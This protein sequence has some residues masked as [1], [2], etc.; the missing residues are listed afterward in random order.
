MIVNLRRQSA[1]L[2]WMAELAVKRRALGRSWLVASIV[3]VKAALTLA[4]DNRYGFHRDE[5]YY[6]VSGRRLD[7]GYV[8]FP[9]LTPVLARVADTLFGGSLLGLRSLALGAGVATLLLTVAMTRHLG[10]HARAQWL[11]ALSVATCGFYL[12]ANG[13]FQTVSFDILAWAVGLYMF[14]RL[15][16]SGN[17]RWWLGVG[18]AVGVGMETKYT[19]PAFVAGLAVATAFT[20]LRRDLRTP[21]PWLGAVI[22]LVIAAPNLA[23]QATQGW[24]SIEFLRGQNARVRGQNPIPKYLSDQ[25]FILGPALIVLCGTGL[26][27]LWRSA[28]TRALLWMAVTV[29]TLYLVAGGKGYYPLDALPVVLAA[30][31]TA[32]AAWTRWRVVVIGLVAWGLVGLPISLPVLPE[33]TMLSLGLDKLRDDYSAELGWAT[34]VARINDGYQT[35]PAQQRPLAFVLTRNYSQAAAVDLYGNR[36]GLPAAHSGHNSYWLWLPDR[37]SLDVV[38]TVGFSSSNLRR[39]FGDVT[40]VGHI[41]DSRQ[42][43]IEERGA[44]IAVCRQPRVT[45]AQLWNDIKLFS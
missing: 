20:S 45:P 18:A 36:Y 23:W 3:A 4:T 14:V 10:G 31:A 41:P 12:G 11:A 33:H 26:I 7:W 39:W 42:I 44:P 43:D 37:P 35:I 24:P 1:T 21:W 9:P 13:L 38:L 29:E 22:A 28:T 19:M 5:L 27:S 16:T 34:V 17:P 40:V 30:G 15:V 2:V 6:V 32:I 8:D 25:L